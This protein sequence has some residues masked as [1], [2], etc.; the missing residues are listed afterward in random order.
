MKIGYVLKY[1]PKLSETFVL[2]EMVAL[3]RAGLLAPLEAPRAGEIPAMY[4]CGGNL[5]EAGPAEGAP[6]AASS[7]PSS[8]NPMMVSAQLSPA[9]APS[10]FP[11]KGAGAV[12][13]GGS[14]PTKNR[15]IP[16]ARTAVRATSDR[17]T[18]SRN[19]QGPTNSRYIGAVDCRKIVLAAVV[20]LFALT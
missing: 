7:R 4:R 18:R 16:V 20:S 6:S 8:R 13:L 10:T 11:S 12:L 14:I 15:A 2:H 1:F 9:S 5:S 3:E 17:R 19:S